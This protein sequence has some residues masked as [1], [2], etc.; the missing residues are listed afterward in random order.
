[1]SCHERKWPKIKEAL[2]DLGF[3]KVLRQ[4]RKGAGATRY[5]LTG[6]MAEILCRDGVEA[7]SEEIVLPSDLDRKIEE[8]VEGWEV[9]YIDLLSITMQKDS[10][11]SIPPISASQLINEWQPTGDSIFDQLLAKQPKQYDPELIQR[12]R[13]AIC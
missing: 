1:M 8:T 6:R 10:Q 2:I 13:C 12:R 4:G 3:I 7:T 9:Q 11:S 5:G